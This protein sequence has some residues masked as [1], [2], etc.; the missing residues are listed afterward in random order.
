[1]AENIAIIMNFNR[2]VRTERLFQGAMSDIQE[3]WA[4]LLDL[5]ANR[6][7]TLVSSVEL[8]KYHRY[9]YSF[10]FL[11]LKT[12]RTSGYLGIHSDTMRAFFNFTCKSKNASEFRWKVSKKLVF[13]T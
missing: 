9:N 2:V 3:K 10:I 5:A 11:H 13:S 8:H 1:M 7:A 6:K 12:L 4:N